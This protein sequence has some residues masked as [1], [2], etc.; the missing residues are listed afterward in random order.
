MVKAIERNAKKHRVK[1]GRV[2]VCSFTASTTPRCGSQFT[3]IPVLVIRVLEIRG[4][5]RGNRDWGMSANRMEHCEPK[6][7]TGTTPRRTNEVWYAAN[8]GLAA[9]QGVAR[10][11]VTGHR[12]ASSGRERG[13]RDPEKK[14]IMPRNPSLL[15][16][17]RPGSR[18]SKHA[19]RVP[20]RLPRRIDAK[21]VL[22]VKE[23]EAM[24]FKALLLGRSALHPVGV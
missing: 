3:G 21:L 4:T 14:L 18:H 2:L 7:D 22:V 8:E 12:G 23:D 19:L 5:L 15:G 11:Q 6:S 17:C 10:A 1:L 20:V 16:G 9:H 24:P 13:V